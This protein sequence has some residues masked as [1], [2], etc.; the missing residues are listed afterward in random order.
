VK[1]SIEFD[2]E[3]GPIVANVTVDGRKLGRLKRL[4]LTLD[5]D[6]E[7]KL[8]VSRLMPGY[9]NKFPVRKDI[10][11]ESQGGKWTIA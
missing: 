10:R 6:G 8:L 3:A 11:L 5:A 1:I 4:E 7:G 2:S 9:G